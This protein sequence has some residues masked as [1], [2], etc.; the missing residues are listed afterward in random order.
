MGDNYH[1]YSRYFMKNYIMKTIENI[2]NPADNAKSEIV[3]PE[4]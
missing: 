4:F 2:Y 1:C 3:K